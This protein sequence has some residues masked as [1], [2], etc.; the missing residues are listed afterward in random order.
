MKPFFADENPEMSEGEIMKIAVKQWR[1]TPKEEKQV[2]ERNSTSAPSMNIMCQSQEHAEDVTGAGGKK[3]NEFESNV[4]E[5]Q[6]ESEIDEKKRKRNED[7]NERMIGDISDEKENISKK[8]KTFDKQ[9][10][11]SKLS[12]FSFT[13]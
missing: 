5:M 2:W 8:V 11:N 1:E 13:K 10:V 7:G 12:T 9:K 4:S 3:I 6:P